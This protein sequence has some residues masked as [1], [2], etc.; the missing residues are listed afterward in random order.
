MSFLSILR[1]TIAY[2]QKYQQCPANIW[3]NIDAEL[4]AIHF[5]VCQRRP[6]SSIFI[7]SQNNADPANLRE[8]Q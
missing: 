2:F 8:L 1:Y 7:E 4:V 5:T 3:Y 6:M